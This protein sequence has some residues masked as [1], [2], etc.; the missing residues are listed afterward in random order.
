MKAP[1][2][3][4]SGTHSALLASLARVAEQ[5]PFDDKLLICRPR[6]VGR[7]LLHALAIAGCGW[8]GF[9]VQTP[10]DLAK[11]LAAPALADKGLAP[12]DG[13]DELAVLDDAIDTVLAGKV[14][15]VLADLGDA[16]GFRNAIAGS[17][18][19]LRLVGMDASAVARAR[20]EDADKGAALAA[21]QDRYEEGLR[22]R[23]YADLADV[24][25]FANAA[26]NGDETELAATRV[27]LLPGAPAR[28][29]TGELID[30]LLR[31]GATVL[32]S[33]P[34]V[35]LDPPPTLLGQA[36]EDLP[37]SSLSLL[38]AVDQL[39]APEPAKNR[40]TPEI[41]HI[42][43]DLFAAASP[44]DELRE[45][46]RRVMDAD[47]PWDT[48]EIVAA[49]RVVYGTALDSI[50]PGLIPGNGAGS[51]VTHAAGLP[52]SRT[53]VGRA[54]AGYLRW[55]Q[56]DF[57]EE[58]IRSLLQSG[59]LRAQ[60]GDGT[61]VSASRAARLLR[62]LHIGW[63]RDRY[64]RQ[65]DWALA[66]LETPST[67][68]D[69]RNLSDDE[70]AAV[71]ERKR[72]DFEALR[73]LIHALLE[74]TP[75][76]PD[77]LDAGVARASPAAIAAGLS[78]F[79]DFVP[80]P[81]DP[82]TE[83]EAK[84]RIGEVLRRAAVTLHR[85]ARFG[86]AVAILERFIDL[87]VPSPSAYGRV[88]WSSSGGH[89]HFS[90][91]DHGG[92][93]GRPNTFV[94]GLDAGRFPGLG[95]QDALLLDHDRG[96]LTAALPIRSEVLEERRFELAGL[97]AR[98]RGRVTLSYS[99]WDASEGR[100][101]SPSP[102]LL[103]AF[104]LKTGDASADYETLHKYTRPIC[105]PVPSTTG[106]IDA[107]DIWLDELNDKGLL[108]H[109]VDAVRRAFAGL[110]RGLSARAA[111]FDTTVNAHNGIIAPRPEVL[112]PRRRG[113]DAP[114][115]ASR[116]ETLATCPLRYFFGN[117]LG[118]RAPDEMVFDPDSWLDAR[119]RGSILHDVYE[120]TIETAK[121]EGIE[122][123]SAAMVALVESIFEQRVES[124]RYRVPTPSEAVF[125]RERRALRADL[126]V[127]LEML[128]EETADWLAAEWSFGYGDQGHPF[129]ALGSGDKVAYLGGYIDRIDELDGNE[130]AIVDY[131]T[132]GAYQYGER[133]GTYN[134][135]RRLQHA[136]YTHAVEQILQRPVAR[137]SYQFPTHNGRGD[138]VEYERSQ[139]DGWPEILEELFEMVAA[140]HFPP[141]FDKDPPCKFCDF[142][143]LCRVTESA[144]GKIDSPPVS[145]AQKNNEMKPE[146]EHLQRVRLIDDPGET[147]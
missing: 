143:P 146:Y 137:A 40:R 138:R 27:Y 49:D 82:D 112:D 94:V 57:P 53:R 16:V 85:K 56:E 65:I 15:K 12:I 31:H 144:F 96:K 20:L 50:A 69:R 103:Q 74:A 124:F 3:I 5:Y 114:L 126:D 2:A 71:T 92:L 90:D 43:I 62:E 26:L 38:Y 24:L 67:H 135:G 29:L 19:E 68:P 77:R 32:A 86:S 58:I 33:D 39:P 25:R 93:G 147:S 80:T 105:G 61:P 139:L 127:F 66:R 123:G 122:R 115:S 6:G 73:H 76:T 1:T 125:E 128:A 133:A 101:L 48:V 37:T 106:R 83:T 110:D 52:V 7:E 134:G 120:K 104:R 140:G 81:E 102:M 30:S 60:R 109:G 78:R 88:P 70:R 119:N 36:V 8:L 11:E 132:G 42:D 51:K 136:L 55:I 99:A 107:A 84:Q 23:A 142:Q 79:L 18:R 95:R 87:R 9:R 98:L 145:W 118:L 41:T 130:L 113:L 100:N 35:G 121:E 72:E 17:V 45:V 54:V 10:R 89:L 108:R 111:R 91:I 22:E 44:V 21:I 59:L 117:V 141:A 75:T 4:N 63:G 13:F 46:L 97:L 129:V 64:E 47:I 14:G 28:G 34:V 116:L 131:K